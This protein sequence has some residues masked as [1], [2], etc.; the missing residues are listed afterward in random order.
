MK[1][2]IFKN[3]IPLI[4]I[5]KCLIEISPLQKQIRAEK[6]NGNQERERELILKASVNWGRSLLDKFG[7]TVTVVGKENLPKKGPVVFV[8]NHQGYGDIPVC[9]ANLDT[10]QLGYISKS[11]LNKIPF[12]SKWIRDIRCVFIKREDPREALKA[13][14][15]GISLIEQGFSM[16][17]FPE[18]TR[19]KGGPMK[20][21][22]QGSLRLATKPGVPIIPITICGT[23]R[24]FEK[25][26]YFKG[27]HV[28]MKI[29]PAIETRDLTKHQ[30][31]E[32]TEQVQ[33]V[34]AEGLVELEERQ[35]KELGV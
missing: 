13:I 28:Y 22:K 33:G 9:A 1:T 23:A 29:H 10:I 26:G 4:K 7:A 2:K 32:L 20:P 31:K 27:E 35:S 14:Q 34:I 25:R 12:Y 6:E 30:Q 16:L 18:G 17:I 21:F 3:I 15:E 24:L 19:S 8:A 5:Y 11:D